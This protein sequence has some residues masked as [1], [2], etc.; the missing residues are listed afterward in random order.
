MRGRKVRPPRCCLGTSS[1]AKIH[2]SRDQR[3]LVHLE[4]R[5]WADGLVVIVILVVFV[6][7]LV[8]E[9]RVM[10]GRCHR[11]RRVRRPVLLEPGPGHAGGPR[12]AGGVGEASDE[13]RAP[14]DRRHLLVAGLGRDHQHGHTGGRLVEVAGGARRQ[15]DGRARRRSPGPLQVAERHRDEQ[16]LI[17]HLPITSSGRR[18]IADQLGGPSYARGVD[19]PL[20]IRRLS[21][22]HSIEPPRSTT[23]GSGRRE[24][25]RLADPR[26][27]PRGPSRRSRP[28]R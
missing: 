16:R 1:F 10:V 26:S 27:G 12:V 8:R 22:V 9:G 4:E 21:T 6:L 19:R 7:A 17:V 14:R 24:G 13:G 3:E 20:L 18:S 28:A 2:P 5:L 23:T 15:D 11:F 25:S